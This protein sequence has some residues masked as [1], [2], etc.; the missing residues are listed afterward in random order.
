[1]TPHNQPGEGEPQGP[2]RQRS[3]S[4]RAPQFASSAVFLVPCR[5]PR[6]GRS[7]CRWQKSQSQLLRQRRAFRSNMQGLQCSVWLQRCRTE[8]KLSGRHPSTSR[9]CLSRWMSLKLSMLRR[10]VM[11]K[12][13]ALSTPWKACGSFCRESSSKAMGLTARCVGPMMTSA[14]VRLADEKTLQMLSQMLSMLHRLPSRDSSFFFINSGCLGCAEAVISFAGLG[15]GGPVLKATRRA[16]APAAGPASRSVRTQ[17]TPAMLS[18]AACPRNSERR[19][20][21]VDLLIAGRSSFS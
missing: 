18:G 4:L 3:H 19:R 10:L 7:V 9:Q 6:R 21:R 13:S 12:F 17:C 15:G 2:R 5:P 11:G 14:S 20:R 1:M 8:P 16:A